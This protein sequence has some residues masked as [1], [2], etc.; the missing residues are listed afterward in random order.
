MQR[1]NLLK[2]WIEGKSIL[3]VGSVGGDLRHLEMWR[4]IQ[5][6]ARSVVGIDTD[7][8]VDEN[9]VCGDMETHVFGKQF[10]VV[11]ACDVIEHVSN[12]GLFLDNIWRHLAT[13]G[14]LLITTPNAK[15][16]TVAYRPSTDHMLWHDRYTLGAVLERH[17]FA[18][19]KIVCYNGNDR[20]LNLPLRLIYAHRGLFA[21]CTK[22]GDTAQ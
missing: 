4:F 11:T 3:D 8:C 1:E 9:V 20:D 18:V 17:G 19:N 22:K 6:H 15:W 12:Q 16:P 7:E 13:D 10:E 14:H 5:E 2:K 21:V